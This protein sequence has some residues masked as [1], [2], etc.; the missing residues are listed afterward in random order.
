MAKWTLSVGQQLMA[1]RSVSKGHGKRSRG[2]PKRLLRKGH[3]QETMA[4][5]SLV[6]GLKVTP[7]GYC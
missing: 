6:I 2:H 7:K 3:R 1:K 5:R 4:K